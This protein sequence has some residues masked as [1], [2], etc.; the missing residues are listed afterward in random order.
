VVSCNWMGSARVGVYLLQQ[1][2]LVVVH[3]TSRR[4]VMEEARAQVSQLWECCNRLDVRV[5]GSVMRSSSF[6]WLY[7]KRSDGGGAPAGAAST[8]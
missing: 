4:E 3:R 7:C 2:L 6:W 5:L 1:Q 8:E